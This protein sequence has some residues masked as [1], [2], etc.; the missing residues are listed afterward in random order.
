MSARRADP[1][2]PARGGDR[3]TDALAE[4]RLGLARIG[5]VAGHERR[6][7]PRVADELLDGQP[8]E[9]L[10][11]RAHRG[12]PEVDHPQHPVVEQPVPAVP[13]A[14]RRHADGAHARPGPDHGRQLRHGLGRDPVRAR[15]PRQRLRV[16]PLLVVGVLDRRL[17]VVDAEQFAGLRV[18]VRPGRGRGPLDQVPGQVLRDQQLGVDVGV[19]H[20]GGPAEADP[21]PGPPPV[22]RDL[23]LD[24]VVVGAARLDDDGP[25]AGPGPQ[26]RGLDQSPAHVGLD[27][28]IGQP[29]LDQL[30]LA[31]GERFEH[32][33]HRDQN[34]AP[35]PEPARLRPAPHR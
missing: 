13:V 11:R 14:V 6:L 17:V 15:E 28:E 34:S 25:P 8:L 35:P 29:R 31:G 23:P 4:P 20:P 2:G 18:G 24:V 22:R 32:P 19:Q 10:R 33:I 3:R 7:R 5:A 9:V 30:R 26:H 16:H 21:R 1:V 12:P 27:R